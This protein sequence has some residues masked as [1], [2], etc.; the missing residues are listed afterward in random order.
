MKAAKL[1]AGVA[2]AVLFAA[3]S[4]LSMSHEAKAS[5]SSNNAP[6]FVVDASWPKPLPSV[7]GHVVTINRAFQNGGLVGQ[8]GTTSVPA[9]PVVEYDAEGNV[10]RAWGDATLL[11]APDNRVAVLPNGIH[12]CFVDYQN[13]V[14]I[15]GNGDGV[16]QKW[17]RSGSRKLLQIGTKFT[18][19]N[20]DRAVTTCQNSATVDHP[21]YQ[22]TSTTLL[23][24]P[25]DMGVDP[26]PD[27]ITGRRGNVYI[28]DGYGNHRV[29]VFNSDGAYVRQWGS[30]G[31]GPGQFGAP[32]GGHPHCVVLGTDNLVYACDRPNSR[33]EVFDRMGNL[34]RVIPIDTSA[35]MPHGNLGTQR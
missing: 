8:D 15:A 10:V 18:C 30:V 12:N 21:A 14:W 19:D 31:N 34:Q 28:A 1:S 3:A 9:P 35:F 22:G 24:N 2:L 5:R 29:A 33:I 25:A 20:A 27:P 17:T 11:P 16:V 32:D 13:N 26:N 4:W 6:R 23:N 7:D